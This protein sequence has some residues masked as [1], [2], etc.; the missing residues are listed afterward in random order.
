MTI[1]IDKTPSTHVSI[2]SYLGNAFSMPAISPM[3]VRPPFHYKDA[4]GTNIMFKTDPQLLEKLVPPPLIP[5]PDQLVL[6]Y[7]GQFHIPDYE[8]SYKEAGLGISVIRDGKPGFYALVLYLDK[9]NPIV[10]GREIWGWP[11]KEAE[12]IVFKD[13]DG[14]I[15]AA[16][17]RYGFPIIKA[18]FE[19]STKVDPIPPRSQ[20][21][22]YFLKLIPSIEQDAPPD[23]L[24]LTT[25][26]MDPYV[27]H[28]MYMGPATL[29][30]GDSPSDPLGQIPIEEIVYSETTVH[31]FTLGYGEIVYDYLADE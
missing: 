7:I 27:I 25:T 30:F 9:A 10:G 20:A 26:V 24:K 5:S 13:E 17:T 11:K 31:D 23:V 21:P 15:T 1:T 29:E 6:F 2:Q 18:T 22:W 19:A 14:K 8:L 28:E 12:E 4:K 16:V 3:L